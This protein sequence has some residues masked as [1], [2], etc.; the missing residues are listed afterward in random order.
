MGCHSL[1][2]GIFPIQGLNPGLLHRQ[3]DSLPL[4]HLGSPKLKTESLNP[5]ALPVKVIEKE[6]SFTIETE[7][8]QRMTHVAGHLSGG[9]K[10][11]RA[12]PPVQ[13]GRPDHCTRGLWVQLVLSL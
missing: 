8:N 7:L 11:E 6:Y 13:L 1:L 3:V 4:S 10:A 9:A 2:Q 12:L 5:E